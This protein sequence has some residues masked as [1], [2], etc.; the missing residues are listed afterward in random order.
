MKRLFLPMSIAVLALVMSSCGARFQP[1]IVQG[2]PPTAKLRVVN[3]SP[4]DVALATFEN[5]KECSVR[6]WI[7]H[8]FTKNALETPTSDWVNIEAKSPATF[9]VWVSSAARS[10]AQMPMFNIDPGKYYTF[11]VNAIKE[12]C[13][14][15][16]LVGDSPETSTTPVE[17]VQ[18]REYKRGWDENSNW[19]R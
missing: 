17:S 2:A 3:E 7:F 19:C 1:Y 4:F 15:G 13:S 9:L 10:C 12:S 6:R 5:A 16:V 18:S 11:V 8:V 14:L